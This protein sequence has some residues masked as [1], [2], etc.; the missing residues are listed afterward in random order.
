M[1]SLKYYGIVHQVERTDYQLSLNTYQELDK[2]DFRHHL[3]ATK[4]NPAAPPSDLEEFRPSTAGI[5]EFDDED[6]IAPTK[7]RKQSRGREVDTLMMEGNPSDSAAELQT[8][9][10]SSQL[11]LTSKR[12]Q[13][14]QQQVAAGQYLG[15][16]HFARPEQNRPHSPESEDGLWY[17]RPDLDDRDSRQSASSDDENEEDDKEDDEDSD[18]DDDLPPDNRN[19]VRLE[20]FDDSEDEEFLK[21]TAEQRR[22]RKSDKKRKGK[23]A[24]RKS[25]RIELAS[26]S[27]AAAAAALTTEAAAIAARRAAPQP[28]QKPT[29]REE[30]VVL[31]DEDDPVPDPEHDRFNLANQVPREVLL[32]ARE[33]QNSSTLTGDS[34]AQ[35]QEEQDRDIV[36]VKFESYWQQKEE[37]RRMKAE[38]EALHRQE[39]DE[40]KESVRRAEQVSQSVSRSVESLAESFQKK[41]EDNNNVIMQGIFQMLN[42]VGFSPALQSGY[43]QGQYPPALSFKTPAD[44][45]PRLQP[46]IEFTPRATLPGVSTPIFGRTSQNVSEELA[47]E[48]AVE[49]TPP[50]RAQGGGNGQSFARPEQNQ[51]SE[52]SQPPGG[53]PLLAGHVSLDQPKTTA[54]EAAGTEEEEPD[55]AEVLQDGCNEVLTS[56]RTQ[57]PPDDDGDGASISEAPPG[58]GGSRGISASIPSGGAADAGNEGGDVGEQN[59]NV[60]EEGGNDEDHSARGAEVAEGDE[61]A[62]N[63]EEH[64]EEEPLDYEPS[65][66]REK[67]KEMTRPEEDDAW[68]LEKV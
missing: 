54:S 50:S 25:A 49:E 27:R 44:V 58:T 13:A 60:R 12:T 15:G 62:E 1:L 55:R 19:R 3:Y 9:D 7:K 17:N 64:V 41:Q 37:K 5:S 45:T 61:V 39:M 66:L 32:E 29:S 30:P 59:S 23:Q 38:S 48:A 26:T 36:K 51:Q 31:S 65:P 35:T 43:S 14:E 52:A 34:S 21:A 63:Q 2:N 40:I 24:Q 33:R 57:F 46:A 16:G 8:V 53:R 47:P 10:V 68:S 18:D 20:N 6:E 42:G 4:V 22:K 67:E 28:Q 56:F 11:F